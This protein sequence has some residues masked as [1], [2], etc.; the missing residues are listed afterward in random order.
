MAT[1]S[2]R[3][4]NAQMRKCAEPSWLH[5]APSAW[6]SGAGASWHSAPDD[7]LRSNIIN[8]HHEQ[9]EAAEVDGHLN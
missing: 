9:K 2:V 3:A 5:Q 7:T 1:L 6:G 8:T 4:A